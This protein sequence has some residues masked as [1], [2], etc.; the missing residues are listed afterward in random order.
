MSIVACS[1]IISPRA[2][3]G[4]SVPLCWLFVPTTAT[5]SSAAM[6]MDSSPHVITT[7][8]QVWKL[9][10]CVR[11]H[12]ETGERF[13]ALLGRSWDKTVTR[14]AQNLSADLSSMQGSIEVDP[15]PVQDSSCLCVCLLSESTSLLMEWVI[16]GD[17]AS[18]LSEE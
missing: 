2:A 13:G 12:I 14:A 8:Y 15:L 17:F 16:A 4:V 6:D 1:V 9:Q 18:A 7:H 10:H 11:K 5:E 3:C